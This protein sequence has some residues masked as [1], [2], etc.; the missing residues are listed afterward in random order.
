[1]RWLS[2]GYRAVVGVAIESDRISAAARAVHEL[3]AAALLGGNL[4]ARVG[5]HPALAHISN[6]RERGAVVNAA[7]RRYG[8]VNSLALAAVVGGWLGARSDETSDARLSGRERRLARFKDVTVAAVALTG[9][10]SAV[11]GVRFARMEPDGRVALDD[12]ST[13]AEQTPKRQARAKRVLGALGGA[14]LAAAATLVAIN[15]SLS[16]ANFRRPPLR[17]VLR[18]RHQVML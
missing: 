11:N 18:R 3:G 6:P 1:M 4:F 15:A 7:W 8:T 9:V 16:Q 10:A 13:P 17:R 14:H 5:M 12:G 2:R